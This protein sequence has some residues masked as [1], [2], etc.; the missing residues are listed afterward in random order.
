MHNN[1]A[2]LQHVHNSG[3]SAI[4]FPPT[5]ITTASVSRTE[6]RRNRSCSSSLPNARSFRHVASTAVLTQAQRGFR[7]SS[8]LLTW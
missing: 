1:G 8:S 2:T 3:A 5:L 4:S 7:A 6:S